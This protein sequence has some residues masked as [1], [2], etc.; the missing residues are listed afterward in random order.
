MSQKIVN[1]SITRVT[2]I[3]TT[4]TM[5][6]SST[7]KIL[8]SVV[9]RTGK[10]VDTSRTEESI[11]CANPNHNYVVIRKHY[12]DLLISKNLKFNINDFRSNTSDTPFTSYHD[13]PEHYLVVR[14]DPTSEAIFNENDS[15]IYPPPV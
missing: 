7:I 10:G 5:E 9:R 6:V 2:E 14:L 4:E 12:L 11:V 13:Q 3:T 1:Y 15:K 8:R